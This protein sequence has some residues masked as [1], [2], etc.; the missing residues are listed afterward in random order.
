MD[1][2]S[3]WSLLGLDFGGMVT[4]LDQIFWVWVR[5]WVGFGKVVSD[6]SDLLG[7]GVW[8]SE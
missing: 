5:I 4:G 2:A 1:D 3:R 8:I 7:N 6:F